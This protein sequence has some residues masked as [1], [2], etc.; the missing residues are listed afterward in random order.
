MFSS[1]NFV[2]FKVS[3]AGI[4]YGLVSFFCS[5]F[6]SM[7][8]RP[9]NQYPNKEETNYCC[10]MNKITTVNYNILFNNMD[11]KTESGD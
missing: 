11:V 1:E 7:K 10:R 9:S 8:K 5:V 4:V 2:K 6:M 3:Q